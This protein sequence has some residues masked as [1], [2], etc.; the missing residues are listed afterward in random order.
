[1][2]DVATKVRYFGVTGL[3]F[4]PQIT[5]ITWINSRKKA[6]EAQ[7]KQISRR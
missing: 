6:Q 2:G 3:C 5:L 4:D 1:M 7:K